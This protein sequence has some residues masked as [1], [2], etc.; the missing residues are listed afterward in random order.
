MVVAYLVSQGMT[1]AMAEQIADGPITQEGSTRYILAGLGI[2]TNVSNGNYGISSMVLGANNINGSAM[3]PNLGVASLV[4][5]FGNSNNGMA[6]F[7]NGKSNNNEGETSFISGVNNNNEGKASFIAGVNN[8][9]NDRYSAALGKGNT[10]NGERSVALG[11]GNTLYGRGAFATGGDCIVGNPNMTSVD[12][13]WAHAEGDGTQATARGAH[14]EGMS[15][16]A[17]GEHSHAQG[18]ACIASG[19]SSFAG[20]NACTASQFASFAFGNNLKATR[21]YQT[22]IGISNKENNSAYFIVGNGL[23]A[24]SVQSNAFEVYEDGS[25]RVMSAPKDDEGVVNRKY[26]ETWVNNFV[27]TYFVYKSGSTM[28]GN[29]KVN[30]APVDDTDVWR[31]GDNTATLVATNATVAGSI[32]DKPIYFTI[33]NVNHANT[34]SNIEGIVFN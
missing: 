15:T 21:P 4:S 31:K 9:I 6:S 3:D 5:G 26:L 14:A 34:A 18:Y 7:I 24:G 2:T 25:A 13:C 12:N 33:N 27:G 23:Q 16:I 8:V 1:Q 22:V 17:S 19:E 32:N 11:S 10:V 20:G 29:L 30:V 28:T